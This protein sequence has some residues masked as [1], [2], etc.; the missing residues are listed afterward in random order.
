MPDDGPVSSPRPT[1]R[2]NAR[3]R[4]TVFD[5]VL[6]LAVVFG[7]VA[8]V[9][10]VTWRPQPDP[11][12]VVDPSG[13][14]TL[15]VAQAEFPVLAPTGLSPQWRS[16][17]ARWEPTEASHDE[18]VLHI[19]YVTPG[20]QYAQVSQVR[21]GDDDYLLE[22]TTGGAREGAVTIGDRTWE[23]WTG[24]KRRSLVLA[25]PE[26]TVVVSGTADWPELTALAESLQPA[27]TP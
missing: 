18:P 5:M 25:T 27:P 15:A 21:E 10:L 2:P 23:T 4:Q 20:D 19:G 17:S 26:S 22:Q 11:V 13:A 1:G 14:I 24:A 8:L 9:L 16:T 3:L 12:R 7:V 6:S